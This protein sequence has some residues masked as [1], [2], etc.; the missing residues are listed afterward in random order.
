MKKSPL[1]YPCDI[2]TKQRKNLFGPGKLF[3]VG[4][5]LGWG[6]KEFKAEP[7]GENAVKNEMK[8]K[9]QDQND[10]VAS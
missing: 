3:D 4:K 8:D 9:L 7:N 5:A 1:K 6:I 10:N 2:G